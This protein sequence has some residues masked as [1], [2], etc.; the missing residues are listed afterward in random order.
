[1]IKS[2]L[3]RA[4]LVLFAVFLSASIAASQGPPP[5]L[6]VVSEVKAGMIINEA[7]FIGTVYYKVVSEVAAE[8]SGKVEEVRFEEGDRI[9]KGGVLVRLD[10]DILEKSIQSTKAS[11][12]QALSDLEKAGLDLKR[13]ESLFQQG[14]AAEQSYDDARLNAQGLRKKAASLKADLEGLRVE[15]A[16]KTVKAP[17]DGV[18]LARHVDRGE[19]A[20]AGG[21][22]A[23]F[24]AY[25]EVDVVVNVPED[26]MRA[27]KTGMGV[28][29]SAGG[30]IFA[31]KVAAIVPSGDVK[32]RTFPVKIRV[33]N[34]SS[35]AEGMDARVR[36]PRG[37]KV[38]AFIVPRDALVSKS[39]STVVFAVVEGTAKMIPVEVAGY[40][41]V[42]AG[43]RAEALKEGMKVVI[44]GNERLNDGA[45]VNI[46]DGRK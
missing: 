44:K 4:F 29:V 41:G 36:L 30:K 19:W 15:L 28:E 22:V 2:R 13:I 10:A 34:D 42:L 9:K 14:L 8:V 43:V 18:V 27:V 31:G 12:E 46:S 32:T 37:E 1:M 11:H 20:E 45:P 6:V 38:K 26:V 3:A 16:K 35:L 33:R 23:T 17:F 24:A 5:A 7:E 21:K 25:G 40:S 39:G